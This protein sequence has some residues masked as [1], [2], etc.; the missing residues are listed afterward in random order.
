MSY[1][2]RTQL[3]NAKNA[4][5]VCKK[6]LEQLIERNQATAIQTVAKSMDEVIEVQVLMSHVVTDSERLIVKMNPPQR[7]WSRKEPTTHPQVVSNSELRQMRRVHKHISD[8]WYAK[9]K[10]QSLEKQI[11]LTREFLRREIQRRSGGAS[12]AAASAGAASGV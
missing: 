11:P 8:R 5:A 7:W 4:L 2:I 1:N 12:A 9:L 3:E 6:E 10:K